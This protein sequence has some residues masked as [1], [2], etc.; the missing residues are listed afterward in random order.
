MRNIWAAGAAF[1][2]ASIAAPALALDGPLAPPQTPTRLDLLPLLEVTPSLGNDQVAPF[3]GYIRF[4]IERVGSDTPAEQRDYG[5]EARTPLNRLLMGRNLARMLTARLTVN[6]T[7]PV[8]QTITLASASHLSNRRDGE[9]WTSEIGERR[10][11]TPY[12]R[13]DQSTTAT[14]EVSLTASSRIDADIAA[15]I[16][17]IIQAGARLAAPTGPLVTALTHD[18]MTQA[19]NFFDN[20]ISRLFSEALVE[21]SLTELPAERWIT[22]DSAGHAQ[23][24]A[25]ITASFPMGRHVWRRDQLRALGGWRIHA[26]EPVVSMFAPL[27]LQPATLTAGQTEP[28]AAAAPVSGKPA[29]TETLTGSD[30]AACRAFRDLLPTRVLAFPVGENV[31]LGQSLRAETAVDSALQRF[32]AAADTAKPTVA[33]EVCVLMSERLDALGLNSYDI[34]A[35]LWAFAQSSS[36]SDSLATAMWDGECAALRLARRLGL[37]KRPASANQVA[38][39]PSSAPAAGQQGNNQQPGTTNG[40]QGASQQ[41]GTTN[42]QQGTSQQPGTTTGH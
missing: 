26:S 8:S 18:R 37:P 9:S 29:N 34:A 28:C 20:A 41:P 30:L 14:I 24:F 5:L 27:P 19:T 16:L 22:R 40:Q 10:N 21:R 13:V 35:A 32:A 42:G 23:P 12:M 38:G 15:N 36:A 11:F 17:S 33:R 31:T 6:R 3:G 4:W 1:G 25:T 39:A 2:L 7:I